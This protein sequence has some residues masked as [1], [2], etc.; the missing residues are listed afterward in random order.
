MSRVA[1]AACLLDFGAPKAPE[2]ITLLPAGRFDTPPGTRPVQGQGPWHLDEAAAHRVIAEW[3]GRR[4]ELLIDFEHQNLRAAENGQPVIA[5]GWAA[6]A[7]MRWEP[8][9]GITAAVR[10]TERARQMIEA[11]EI[12]YL[13]PV[14][15][16]DKSGAVLRLLNTTLTNEPALD[17]FGELLAAAA[18][19]LTAEEPTMNPLLRAVLAALAL[20]EDA[21]EEQVTAALTALKAKADQVSGLTDQVAALKSQAPDPAKFAPVAVVT[22]LRDQVAALTAAQHERDVDAVVTAALAEGKL[23]PAQE[24]W[25]RAYGKSDLAGLKS[26]LA[27]AQPI[28]ALKGTQTGGQPPAGEKGK[29]AGL[30]ETE[31]AVCRQMGVTPEDFA[32]TRAEL[33]A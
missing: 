28:A 13:S 25:A 9:I 17:G 33:A 16:Y 6:P 21:T 11:G 23:L 14:F 10:W 12:R 32:K 19:R 15:T 5:G 18:R 26:Y 22:E 7:S 1:L 8:G 30:S 2:R 24:D 29:G 3:Q 4:G 31:L 27:A 20:K